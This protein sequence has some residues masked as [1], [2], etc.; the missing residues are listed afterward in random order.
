MNRIK[1]WLFEWFENFI[2]TDPYEVTLLDGVTEDGAGAA[3]DVTKYSKFNAQVVGLT[4]GVV[5]VEGSIDGTTYVDISNGG[6]TDANGIIAI[7][8][9]IYKKVRGN[10]ASYSAGTIYLYLIVKHG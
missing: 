5:T 4:T 9:G 3:Y 8:A 7:D 1:A 10:V 2:K 6:K